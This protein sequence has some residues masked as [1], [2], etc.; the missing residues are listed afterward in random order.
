MTALEGA[1][2]VATVIGLGG[3][4]AWECMRLIRKLDKKFST[5]QGDW[6]GTESRPGV[7]RRAG[8]MERLDI[9]EHELT[10]NSGTSVKDAV[11]RIDEAING[12]RP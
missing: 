9:I 2:A 4:S 7:P 5:F 6:E 8:V 10:F 3:G 1:A 11:T 12:K